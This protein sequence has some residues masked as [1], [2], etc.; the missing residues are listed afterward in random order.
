M[1]LWPLDF[2]DDKDF[3]SCLKSVE[4]WEFLFELKLKD[5]DERLSRCGFSLTSL[6]THLSFIAC[7]NLL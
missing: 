3:F 5:R 2:Y 6:T 1:E 4:V 7:V